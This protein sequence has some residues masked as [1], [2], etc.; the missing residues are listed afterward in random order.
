LKR[1]SGVST[2][3]NSTSGCSAE[4]RISNGGQAR[5]S[6]A[7][8]NAKSKDLRLSA[9]VLLGGVLDA[10]GM[11]DDLLEHRAHEFADRGEAGVAALVQSRLRE[12]TRPPRCPLPLSSVPGM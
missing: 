5:R 9:Q 8:Q 4:K 7:G 6:D 1:D 12:S 3:V 2:S 10:R 11:S